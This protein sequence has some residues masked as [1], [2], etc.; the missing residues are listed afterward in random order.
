MS[1]S[2]AFVVFPL[3]A[4]VLF[5]LA[6][7]ALKRSSQLGVGIWQTAFVANMVCAVGY[8]LLW[9]LGGPAIDWRL[10]WQP[11]A[12]ALCLCSGMATQFIALN[13]GDVSVAVPILGLKVLIVPFL[14]PWLVGESVRADLWFS[15]LLSVI[16]VTFLNLRV[17]GA[18]AKSILPALLAGGVSAFSFAMF[19]VLVQKWGP[20][21]GAGRLL[22][23]VFWMNGLLTLA[24]YWWSPLDWNS[25]SKPAWKWLLLGGFLIGAQSLLF[26]GCLAIYGGAV[27]ANIVYAARGLLS[28]ILIWTIGH[29]FSSAESSLGPRVLGCR[30]VGAAFLLAAIL[31]TILRR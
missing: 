28:V 17:G 9:F 7:L 16:G 14:T 11:A 8:S 13:R 1:P 27:T 6:A 19:D 2:T 5:S 24:A 21:W 25:V 29:W 20:T 26:V 4:A 30:L 3:S 23:C 31:F 18:A 12:I 22:P 10:L 15:A